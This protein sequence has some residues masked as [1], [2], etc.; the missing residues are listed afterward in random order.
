M[1]EPPIVRRRSNKEV[2]ARD[3]PEKGVLRRKEEKKKNEEQIEP[4][5]EGRSVADIAV[6]IVLQEPVP[7][8]PIFTFGRPPDLS[9]Q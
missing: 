3:N 7:I 2:P 1:R 8:F 5:R 9:V 4:P 6:V